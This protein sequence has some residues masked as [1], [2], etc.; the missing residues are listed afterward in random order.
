MR[1]VGFEE[2]VKRQS[3]AG[4]LNQRDAKLVDHLA[5]GAVAA[6]EEAGLDLVGLSAHV[7]TDG[8]DD[9]VGGGAGES[10]EGGVWREASS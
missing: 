7:V 1:H 6:E 9:A 4:L 2:D 10:E 3:L 8:A 5:A